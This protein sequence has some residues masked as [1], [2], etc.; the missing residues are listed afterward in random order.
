MTFDAFAH[1]CRHFISRP[2][3]DV[4]FHEFADAAAAI[5]TLHWRDPTKSHCFS[6]CWGLFSRF[7]YHFLRRMTIAPTSFISRPETH[8]ATFV[9]SLRRRH[10]HLFTWHI[11]LS[12]ALFSWHF[13]R[14]HSHWVILFLSRYR[15]LYFIARWV[16]FHYFHFHI[17]LYFRYLLSLYSSISFFTFF[18]S[19]SMS[20][21][22]FLFMLPLLFST[23]PIES[24]FIILLSFHYWRLHHYIYF[25]YIEATT[26]TELYERLSLQAETDAERK[27]LIADT[28]L[29]L[30]GCQLLLTDELIYFV[31][32]AL[33]LLPFLIHFRPAMT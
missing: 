25:L 26:I 22:Y 28:R 9:S 8:Y 24:L 1:H 32:A 13:H 11:S 30:P 3:Y 33:L 29:P 23:M 27:Y 31:A 18:I 12:H 10:A 6:P 2:I 20:L 15:M 5:A 16:Y 21:H 14:P 7:R 4:L 19:A 17:S